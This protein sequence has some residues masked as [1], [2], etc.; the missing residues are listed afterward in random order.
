MW[1]QLGTIVFLW[2]AFAVG[3]YVLFHLICYTKD[4]AIGQQTLLDILYSQMFILMIA[5]GFA[6][7]INFTLQEVEH[8]SMPSTI[9]IGFGSS[10]LTFSVVIHFGICGALRFIMIY[11][12]E[13]LNEVPDHK[14]EIIVW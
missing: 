2:L 3:C 4:K 14:V 5:A 10:T 1:G 12:P 8:R 6:L 13:D 9:L 11:S 7:S